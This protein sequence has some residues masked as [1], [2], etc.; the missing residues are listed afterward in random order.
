MFSLWH[1][2]KCS[3]FKNWR[4]LNIETHIRDRTS[5]AASEHNW[6]DNELIGWSKE[7]YKV[8]KDTVPQNVR[9]GAAGAA[10]AAACPLRLIEET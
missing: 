1:E 6:F 7:E 3:M 4:A 2:A 8:C 9:T 5:K 10:G